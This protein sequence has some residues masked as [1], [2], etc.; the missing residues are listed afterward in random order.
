VTVLGFEIT[1]DLQAPYL[2]VTKLC[3][4]LAAVVELAGERL[5]LLVDNL[6]CSDIAALC[7]RL[8]ADVTGVWPLA[9]VTALMCLCRVLAMSLETEV[10]FRTF[11]LPSCEN[12][13]PQDGSLHS[14]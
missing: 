1:R 12:R 8:A 7:E 5:D 13:W 3:E 4:L 11:K 10:H 6:V 14:C 2:E 9:G